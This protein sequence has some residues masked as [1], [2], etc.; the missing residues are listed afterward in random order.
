MVAGAAV[1]GTVVLDTTVV[2][3]DGVATVVVGAL[4]TVVVA[5]GATFVVTLDGARDASGP[6]TEPE[7]S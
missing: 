5:D 7:V 4:T 2:E 1:V 6:R 3:G